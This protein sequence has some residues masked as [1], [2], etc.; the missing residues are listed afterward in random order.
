MVE[1]CFKSGTHEY[2]FS[3]FWPYFLWSIFLGVKTKESCCCCCEGLIVTKGIMCFVCVYVCVCVCMRTCVWSQVYFLYRDVQLLWRNSMEGNYSLCRPSL[4]VPP[5][6]LLHGLVFRKEVDGVISFYVSHTKCAK[7]P[8]P[9]LI[10][11]II[12]RFTNTP[13]LSLSPAQLPSSANLLIF[14]TKS[15]LL[16]IVIAST[17]FSIVM[18]KRRFC[19]IP[20]NDM[21]LTACTLDNN[22]KS[23]IN[24]L[25]TRKIHLVVL[26]PHQDHF[27]R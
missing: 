5:S 12:L 13:N 16:Y 26:H 15:T 18:A 4:Y 19:L 3:V 8:R 9:S 2:L 27:L 6:W 20:N 24:W 21:I 10:T 11:G 7:G 14:H 25:T 22:G 23:W 1:N 17:A